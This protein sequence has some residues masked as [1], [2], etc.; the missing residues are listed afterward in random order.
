MLVTM[1]NL[2]LLRT[3]KNNNY[4]NYFAESTKPSKNA[5]QCHNGKFLNF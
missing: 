2:M 5:L 1:I 3:S 4:S